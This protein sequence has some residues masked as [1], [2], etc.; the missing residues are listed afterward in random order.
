MGLPTDILNFFSAQNSKVTPEGRKPHSVGD[1]SRALNTY[2][3]VINAVIN[4]LRLS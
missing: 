2:P 1:C 3:F 4:T